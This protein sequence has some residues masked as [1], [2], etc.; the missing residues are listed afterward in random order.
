MLEY[1]FIKSQGSLAHSLFCDTKL[2]PENYKIFI[3]RPTPAVRNHFP[4]VTDYVRI[5]ELFL[6]RA[7][8]G[9][10]HRS[11]A[12]CDSCLRHVVVT[13]SDHASRMREPC[14]ISVF[15]FSQVRP[16][17]WQEIVNT[18]LT[19][20]PFPPPARRIVFNC[21]TYFNGLPYEV[22]FDAFFYS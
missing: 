12:W 15:F 13:K 17:Q 2:N 21:V 18:R 6:L 9:G 7:H 5:V 16:H 20:S 22:H 11:K 14:V 4:R 19:R 1:A 8:S 3:S 10:G